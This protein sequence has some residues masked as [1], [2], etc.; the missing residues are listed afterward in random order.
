[1]L[2]RLSLCLLLCCPLPL[3]AQVGKPE[4]LVK[5]VTAGDDNLFDVAASGTVHAAPEVVWKILTDY[6]RMPEFVPDMHKSKVVSRYG[7]LAV[8]EQYG[9]ARF[10]FFKRPIYL[11]VNVTE[12]PISTI[13]IAL[14]TGDMKTY[15]CRW[16]LV[17]IPE[18]G[19]TRIVYTGKLVPK[20]YVPG[21]LGSNIIRSD[22][23]KMMA[24]VLARLDRAD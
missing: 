15:T 6:E 1:M 17:P 9:E 19:G 13:D 14:V 3:L 23:E 7:N 24:A 12:Q 10:L 5:R 4:V 21:M 8:V 16:E 2:A 20:F 11:V 22:I 18:T